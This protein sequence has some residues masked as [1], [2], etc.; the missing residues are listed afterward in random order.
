MKCPVVGNFRNTRN[1]VQ[2]DLWHVSKLYARRPITS[3]VLYYGGLYK[4]N[5]NHG[6]GGVKFEFFKSLIRLENLLKSSTYHVGILDTNGSIAQVQNI[7]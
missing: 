4:L 7:E 2:I 5:N 3:A 6:R 1:K